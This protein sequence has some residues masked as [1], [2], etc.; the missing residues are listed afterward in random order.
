MATSFVVTVFLS[1]AVQVPAQ[2]PKPAMA[3]L[4]GTNWQVKVTPDEAAAKK[5]EKAFDDTIV[6]KDGKVSMSECVKVGFAASAYTATKTAD[7]WSFKTEQTSDKEGKAVWNGTTKGDTCKGTLVWTKKD[8]TVL[9]YTFDGK[10]VEGAHL[11]GMSFA[12]KVT[13]DEAAA[14][15]GEKA[16]DDTIVFK[17]GKVSMSECVKVGF[18]ATPY[19]AT[20]TAD[21]WSFKTEQTS[22]KEGKAVWSGDIKGDTCKGTMVWTKK[23]GTVLNY[24]FGGAK[25][26]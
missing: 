2:Q 7:G 10:K 17:D 11:D 5:G 19:T 26:K 1:L 9:N 3:S 6:F 21:G 23:D 15:K 25:A 8:G 13:P 24:T 22:D 14:K 12:V 16:F 20:K 4:D 18:A